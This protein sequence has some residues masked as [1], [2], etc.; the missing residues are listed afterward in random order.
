[1]NEV[2]KAI[3][4]LLHDNRHIPTASQVKA[5]YARLPAKSGVRRIVLDQFCY[6]QDPAK[7]QSAV[8]DYPPE[9]FFDIWATIGRTHAAGAVS[10][11]TPSSCERYQRSA[12][13]GPAKLLPW[14]T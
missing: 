12:S 8:L 10:K 2:T 5:I 1:M 4:T 9:F 3:V 11:P 7:I 6:C 14:Q 13:V